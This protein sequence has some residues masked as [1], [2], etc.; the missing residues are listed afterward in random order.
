[1]VT[2]ANGGGRVAAK[3]RAHDYVKRQVRPEPFR[4]GN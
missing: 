1:M 2:K 3:D 4:A